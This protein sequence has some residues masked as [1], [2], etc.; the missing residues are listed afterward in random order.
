[1][2]HFILTNRQKNFLEY[3]PLAGVSF[4]ATHGSD[5]EIVGVK[6]G[7]GA[8][9]NIIYSQQQQANGTTRKRA[10]LQGTLLNNNTFLFLNFKE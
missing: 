2:N 6:L 8:Q 9:E 4:K 10:S 3:N 5:V 1:M 7:N